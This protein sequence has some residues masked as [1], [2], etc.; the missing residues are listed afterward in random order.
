MGQ[1]DRFVSSVAQGLRPAKFHEKVLRPGEPSFRPIF[2]FSGSRVFKR[3]GWFFDPVGQY[4]HSPGSINLVSTSRA[5]FCAALF[6]EK[7]SA[8]PVQSRPRRTST[9]NVL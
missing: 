2:A 8:C 4:D 1:V 3:L 5:A 7:P 6:L 9:V